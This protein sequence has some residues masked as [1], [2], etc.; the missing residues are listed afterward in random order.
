MY[1][2]NQIFVWDLFVRIFQWLLGVA[3][4]SILHNENLVRAMFAGKKAQT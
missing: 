3:V 2:N 4:S 1:T